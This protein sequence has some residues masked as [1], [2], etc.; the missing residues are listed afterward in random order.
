MKLLK[1]L[2]GFKKNWKSLK[3][4][5]QSSLTKKLL[6][7]NV[8]ALVVRADSGVYAI[9]PEDLGV[10]RRLR[11]R[12]SYGKEEFER[13]CRLVPKGGRAMIV[14][15]HV[16]TLAIPLS[17]HCRETVAIEANPKT[18]ELLKTNLT[19]NGIAN[20]QAFNFAAS[21]KEEQIEFLLS[22]VNS[23]GSKRV[24]KNWKFSYYADSPEKVKVDAKPLDSLVE[25]K[26]FDLV[27]MDIEGS[28][29][30]A[31]KGM[32]GILAQTKA[33]AVEFLP[34]MLRDVA[35]IG[36]K[37]LLATLEPHFSKVSIPSRGAELAFKDAAPVF[38]EMFDSNEGDDGTIFMK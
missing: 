27:V 3:R 2:R 38:Q 30:L 32:Q 19:L 26:A 5:I 9:D 33:L 1:R 34:Q 24:P 17:K 31:L 28:E 11:A 37:E 21:D 7:P 12:G 25:D 13:L 20:C 15:T 16:G 4:S 35:G 18:F 23:G 22:R 10:G 8:F 36:P 6:G 14:G 29:Y